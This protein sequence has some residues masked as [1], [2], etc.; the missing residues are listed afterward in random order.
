M[1][2]EPGAEIFRDRQ[3]AED[4]PI[5]GYVADPE[6]R[7]PVRREVGDRLALEEHPAT[8]RTDEPHDRLQG[9]A[10]TDPVAAEEAHHL[11]LAHFERH[12]VEDMAL[13]VVGMDILD[14]DE[15]LDCRT[16][17]AHVFR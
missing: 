15:W 6:P 4:P 2:I 5:F 1:P 8:A 3:Q 11:A 14:F 10:L 12:P 7:Q 16:A 13:A 9:R 17:R